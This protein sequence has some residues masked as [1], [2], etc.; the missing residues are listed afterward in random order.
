MASMSDG[1]V[2]EEEER[3]DK[4][5][6]FSWQGENSFGLQGKRALAEFAP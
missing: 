2:R 1:A 5:V 6:G 3:V 4:E